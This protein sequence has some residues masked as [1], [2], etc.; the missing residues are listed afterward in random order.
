MS[1]KSPANEPFFSTTIAPE[2]YKSREYYAARDIVNARKGA[3]GVLR[4]LR[5]ALR[6]ANGAPVTIA[7]LIDN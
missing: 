1:R 7:I 5:E 3:G 2:T 6:A 4:N